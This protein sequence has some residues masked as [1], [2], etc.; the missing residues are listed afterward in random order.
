MS[1]HEINDLTPKKN[2]EDGGVYV[3]ER[4]KMIKKSI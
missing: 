2:Q 4:K 3:I 1:F